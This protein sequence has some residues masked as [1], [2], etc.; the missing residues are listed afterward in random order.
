MKNIAVDGS[1]HRVALLKDNFLHILISPR[2]HEIPM[3]YQLTIVV[4]TTILLLS[5][6]IVLAIERLN[7]ERSCA[8]AALPLKPPKTPGSCSSVLARKD[9]VRS[10]TLL[11]ANGEAEALVG[12][13][14][15]AYIILPELFETDALALD[16]PTLA[17]LS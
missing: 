7:N 15:E 6:L 9:F 16:F 4:Y 2:V 1:R 12:G 10:V 14:V 3:R 17:F 8:A 5:G 13:T 11:F